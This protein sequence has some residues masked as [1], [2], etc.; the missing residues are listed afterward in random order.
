MDKANG[1]TTG[2]PAGVSIRNGPVLDD[3]MDVDTPNTNG[4]TKRKSRASTSKPVKYNDDGSSDSDGA[5]L[6]CYN[7]RSLAKCA[8]GS[9]SDLAPI[10][11]H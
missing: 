9:S 11:G 4:T 7:F 3:K 2:A 5:P 10:G 8:L 1:K 6:V